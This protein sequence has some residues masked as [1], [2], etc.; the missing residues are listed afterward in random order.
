MTF[1]EKLGD[2]L[3]R[4][5]VAAGWWDPDEPMTLRQAAE[6][7]EALEHARRSVALGE[8]DPWE[9]ARAAG[10][11]DWRADWALGVATFAINES[12]CGLDHPEEHP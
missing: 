5:A 10:L 7:G 6:L 1:S 12:H 11:T 9:V 2:A 8:R 3:R 4:P